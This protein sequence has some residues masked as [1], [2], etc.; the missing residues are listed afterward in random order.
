MPKF[1]IIV[2]DDDLMR[3]L[4]YLEQGLTELYGSWVEWIMRKL[5]I[6]TSERIASLPEKTKKFGYPQVYWVA[7]PHH[8]NFKD[9]GARS[10]MVN[11]LETTCKQFDFIRLI[12]M[13]EIW[14]YEDD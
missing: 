12:R 3:Y 14:D 8:K 1:V 5:E 11:A 2:L 13:K 7:L 10:R 9:N 4:D 6:M